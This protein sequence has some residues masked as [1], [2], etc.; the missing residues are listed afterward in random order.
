[1]AVVNQ[2]LRDRLIKDEGWKNKV[3]RDGIGIAT[4][5]VGFNL[6]EG[7]Y[8]EEINFCLDFRIKRFT[9]DLFQ[10]LPWAEFLDDVRRN[11]LLNM[12][13]NL[14]VPR[15]LQFKKLLQALQLQD[16]H[17]AKMECL[18]SIWHSQVPARSSRIADEF[19]TGVVS[20]ASNG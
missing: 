7:F 8:D 2:Q 19:L 14:G 17:Q 18:N 6:N 5:G 4:W 12:A 10:A 1:M 11:A 16:W 15:L 20:N 13:Y 9:T 3:Y